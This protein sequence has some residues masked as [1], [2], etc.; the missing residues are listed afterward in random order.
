M[1][2][3][4]VPKTTEMVQ[5][6][7][8]VKGM[9]KAYKALAEEKGQK[10]LREKAVEQKRKTREL[11]AGLRRVKVATSETKTTTG[12]AKRKPLMRKLITR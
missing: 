11:V 6:H 10:S 8:I 4:H 3:R 9:K 12:A 2:I 1:V 7:L 5:D